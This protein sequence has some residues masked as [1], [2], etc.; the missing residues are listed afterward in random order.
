LISSYR[1]VA[2]TGC[3]LHTPFGIENRWIGWKL[4]GNPGRRGHCAFSVLTQKRQLDEFNPRQRIVRCGDAGTV[5]KFRRFRPIPGGGR[6]L[7]KTE[8]NADVIRPSFQEVD[9]ELLGVL[10]APGRQIL[11]RHRGADGSAL[12]VSFELGRQYGLGLKRIPGAVV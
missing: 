3:D 9:K 4:L 8:Q 12:R 1:A 10:H 7:G 11:P 6:D 2:V 5:D